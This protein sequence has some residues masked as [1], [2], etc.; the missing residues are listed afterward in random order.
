MYVDKLYNF[1]RMI[2][3]I[4]QKEQGEQGEQ[5]AESAGRN[6]ISI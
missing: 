6:N 1:M 2:L 5:R 4:I 3:P